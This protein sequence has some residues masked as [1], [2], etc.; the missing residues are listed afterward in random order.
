MARFTGFL[1]QALLVVLSF[2]L[3]V[4]HNTDVIRAGFPDF[5]ETAANNT[6]GTSA[7]SSS[8]NVG[9]SANETQSLLEAG[10]ALKGENAAPSETETPGNNDRFDSKGGSESKSKLEASGSTLVSAEL[11]REEEL[12]IDES[13]SPKGGKLVSIPAVG[14]DALRGARSDDSRVLGVSPE[15]LYSAPVQKASDR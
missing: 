2:W 9:N 12:K 1:V 3:N 5:V 11:A 13:V 4:C 6:D 15:E 10:R 8:V 14:V 7:G